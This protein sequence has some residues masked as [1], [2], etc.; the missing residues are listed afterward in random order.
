MTEIKVDNG[1]II[2]DPIYTEPKTGLS[3]VNPTGG[4]PMGT[5]ITF[6]DHPFRGLVFAAPTHFY[7]GGYKYESEIKVGDIVMMN[8]PMHTVK[9]D[10]V[11]F[12]GVD[13]DVVRYASVIC[14][15]TPTEEERKALKFLRDTQ[16]QAP[17]RKKEV[18]K[19]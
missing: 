2:I 9:S 13:Y 18:I 19:N 6:K 3:L 12:D 8:E 11:I 4:R 10:I 1:F 15:V 16:S 17:S 7:N 14:H 5:S